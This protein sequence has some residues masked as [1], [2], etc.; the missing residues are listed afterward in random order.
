MFRPFINE[1]DYMGKL[2]S[3]IDFKNKIS[4]NFIT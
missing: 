1:R 4:K 3:T 2:I